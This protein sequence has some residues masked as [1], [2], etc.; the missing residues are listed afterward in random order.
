RCLEDDARGSAGGG[1]HRRTAER[2]HRR[3]GA[4]RRLGARADADCR[5]LVQ[6]LSDRRAGRRP[7]TSVTVTRRLPIGAELVPALPDGA[8]GVHF[9]VWAPGRDRVAVVIDG[10]ST[11]LV[12]ESMTGG[13]FSGI[14]S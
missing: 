9:R 14:V 3:D 5:G 13:Y 2:A 1:E 8:G 7:H 6:D 11:L 12:A 10:Q 4:A